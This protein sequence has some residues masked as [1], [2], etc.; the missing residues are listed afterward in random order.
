MAPATGLRGAAVGGVEGDHLVFKMNAASRAA[1]GPEHQAAVVG[2]D[3]LGLGVPDRAAGLEH[4]RVAG[5]LRVDVG[6]DAHAG[7]GH[8]R[9]VA[10]RADFCTGVVNAPRARSGPPCER[11]VAA[12]RGDVA[13]GL[14]DLQPRAG[15]RCAAQA[16]RPGGGADVA[17]VD[18]D[19]LVVVTRCAGDV[20][21]AGRTLGGQGDGIDIADIEADVI[22]RSAAHGDAAAALRGVEVQPRIHLNACLRGA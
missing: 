3:G 16:D 14:V 22:G 5:T 19:T 1:V 10:R 15:A 20:D 7:V 13:G 6:I 12:G 11:H 18:E 9:D 17:F 21:G 4:Q 2:L 8:E